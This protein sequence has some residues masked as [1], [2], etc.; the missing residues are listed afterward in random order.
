MKNTLLIIMSATIFAACS[1]THKANSSKLT[2]ET[3]KDPETKVLRGYINRNILETDT[4]F[5]WFNENMKYG[6][7]DAEAVN[8]FKIYGSNFSMIVFGG[9][10]CHDTQNLL[11]VFY[12][13]V[14]K[15]GYPENKITLIAV[16]RAKTAP[17]DLQKTYNIT[18]VP[19]FI[20]IKNNKEVGR[21]VEYGKEGAIDK[22]LG[23]I[24]V[25]ASK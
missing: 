25:N 13:L 20:V 14:D 18:N 2:Y 6:R 19:T 3:I 9:T 4:S 1:S 23:Q 11:S 7:A 16:D 17:G 8:A 22:E 10:W 12:R 15:S 21:V 24:V 5:K